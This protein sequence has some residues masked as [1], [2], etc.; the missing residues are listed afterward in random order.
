MRAASSVIAS[1]LLAPRTTIV[2]RPAPFP[3]L[4]G[5]AVVPERRTWPWTLRRPVAAECLGY[6]DIPPLLAIPCCPLLCPRAGRLCV[7]AW[8]H[9]GSPLVGSQGAVE[10]LIVWE[11]LAINRYELKNPATNGAAPPLRARLHAALN[12]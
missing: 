2:N 9:C 1:P 5:H 11:N 7:C 3:W 6:R 8:R 10:T 4:C 12:T